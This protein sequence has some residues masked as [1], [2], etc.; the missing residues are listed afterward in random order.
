MCRQHVLDTVIMVSFIVGII[1][2]SV[3]VGVITV[4]FIVGVITVSFIVGDN[5]SCLFGKTYYEGKIAGVGRKTLVRF[6]S[7]CSFQ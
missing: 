2:V 3:I 6:A 5:V 4:S 1:T 7:F